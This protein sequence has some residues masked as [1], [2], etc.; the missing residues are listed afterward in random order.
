MEKQKAIK[1]LKSRA[2]IYTTIY[3]GQL[4][5]RIASGQMPTLK[6]YMKYEFIKIFFY[7]ETFFADKAMTSGNF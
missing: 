4:H 2:F 5:S 1:L 6:V 7:M 3:H